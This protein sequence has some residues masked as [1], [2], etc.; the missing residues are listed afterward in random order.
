MKPWPT[1]PTAKPESDAIKYCEAA[2]VVAKFGDNCEVKPKH[3]ER[4]PHS[5]E[6]GSVVEQSLITEPRPHE[7]DENGRIQSMASGRN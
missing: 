6:L 3:F 7:L 4:C 1:K 2:K 5:H